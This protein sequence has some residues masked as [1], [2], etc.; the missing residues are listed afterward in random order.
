M[1]KNIYAIGG[2]L[3]LNSQS[4]ISV[5]GQ[6][7]ANA[8]TPGYRR[9]TVEM[10]PSPYLEQYGHVFGTGSEISRLR[11]HF[12]EYLARQQEGKSGENS[13]WQAVKGNLAGM[14]T[15][16]K[17]SAT[18]GLTKAMTDFW[19]QWQT[20]SENPEQD[21][22]RTSLLGKTE[23]MI[24]LLRSKRADM[25]RQI[26]LMNKSIGQE[27]SRVNKLMK[28][29][30]EINKQIVG[31]AGATN[32]AD[33]RDQIIEEM[34]GI[35]SVKSII[36]EN[37]QA[38]VSLV[39]GQTLVDGAHAYKFQFSGP[40]IGRHLMEASSF[41]DTVHYKGKGIHEYTIECVTPGPA[42][43]SAGSAT[44]RVSLDGGKTWLSNS[45]GS[46]KKF[47]ANGPGNEIKIGDISVWFGKTTDSGQ[48]P[49]TNLTTGDKFIIKPKKNL[50]W[51]KNS[52]TE[53]DITP[54]EGNEKQLAGG[55]LAGLLKARDMH[56]ARYGKKLDA[57]AKAVVWQVNFAHSQGAGSTHL[58]NTVGTYKADKVDRPLASTN[59]PF[60][61]N[62]KKGN[63]SIAIYDSANGQ[64][65]S[66]KPVDF[67]S[68]AP[69]GVA[70]FDPAV[71]SLNDV[72]SAITST[73]GPDVRATVE[74]GKLRLTSASNRK[75]SF[76]GD[77]SGVLAG[78][79]INSF[80]QGSSCEDIEINSAVKADITRICAG[81][82]NGAGE[83]NPGDNSIART[84]ADLSTAQATFSLESGDSTS[85]FQ[86]FLSNLISD[87][88][89]DYATAD[90]AAA[91]SLV[92]L[93]FLNNRQEEV[94][95]VNVKEEMIKLKQYQQHFQTASKLINIANEMYDTLLS[96]K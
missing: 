67:S 76:A 53:E 73:Y 6:N 21:A 8:S 48:A 55:S 32:L 42:D 72:A 35:V 34:S 1:L 25:D 7:M 51:H 36:R 24:N 69:P 86:E 3:L 79:G 13:M 93:K 40:S 58:T 4:A 75:F 22:A 82:V 89:S 47:T 45:D 92:Q 59:L 70:A 28:Q 44:F 15:L 50:F 52:S 96:L 83:V 31:N 27:T 10:A 85:T 61:S 68:I 60:A 81:H 57:L 9:R 94:G 65:L 64:H 74:D 29:L 20:L 88:G 95:G 78:L 54:Y 19:N 87:V 23:T 30:A 14:D 2:S 90:S 17:D 16:F 11:R 38:T 49:T 46:D 18:K 77:S 91:A 84:L 43:G 71:H 12:D 33:A 26:E 56:V 66:S 80:L 63:F 5:H 41:T 39:G 37:G 62:M